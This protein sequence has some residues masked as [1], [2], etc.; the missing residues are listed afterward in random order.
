MWNQRFLSNIGKYELMTIS[1]WEFAQGSVVNVSHI[2]GSKE[3][4][5]PVEKS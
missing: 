5:I 1:R 4:I 2:H 3:L